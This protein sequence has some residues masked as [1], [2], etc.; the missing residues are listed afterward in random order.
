MKTKLTLLAISIVLVAVPTGF[1]QPAIHTQPQSLTNAVGTTAEF[2]V[3]ATG[4]S[5]LAYQWQKW[6]TVWYS[7]ASCTESNLC[8]TNVQTGYAADYRVVITNVDGAIT[9]EVARLTVL[10]PPRIT[11]TTTFQH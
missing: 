6:T 3:G 2:W 4:A 7:L 1:S 10:A 5:P 8:L 11:P 9:S